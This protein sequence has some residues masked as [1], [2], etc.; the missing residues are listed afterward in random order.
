MEEITKFNQR[1]AKQRKLSTILTCGLLVYGFIAA[2]PMFNDS[3]KHEETLYCNSSNLCE[4]SNIKHGIS[5]LIDRERRNQ[6]FDNNIR[7]IKILPPEDDK[8]FVWG[9]V[10][11][12]FL[13]SSYA[14]SKSITN[15]QEKAIHSQF[16]LLKIKA[17]ENDLLEQAHINLFEFSKQ[18]QAEITKQAIARQTSETIQAM[19]SEAELQLDHLNG[20]L[21]GELSLKSHELQIAELSK[22]IAENLLSEAELKRKL[23]KIN[24]PMSDAKQSTA[25]EQVKQIL[26]EALKNHEDGWLWT[27][28]K[29][30]KPLWIIGEQGTGKTNTS[31]AVG[32]VRKYCLGVAVFR[33]ADRHLNGANSKVWKLLEAKEKADN[34]LAII[35]VLQDTYERRLKRI[36]LDLDDKQAEQF[37]LDEFTHLKDIDEETVKKF[38]KSTFSDTRKAKERFIGVTHLG[39][40]E[41]FGDGTA[42]MR[43]AGSILIEKFTADGEKPLSRVVIKH[44]L[45][46]AQGNKLEDVEHTLPGWFEAFTIHKHFND[47]PIDF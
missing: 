44:G 12:L 30:V 46:D 23:E 16:K 39:T 9:I 13:L 20:Q 14:L 35:E 28:I 40:N 24:K 19:K 5:Y 33:I 4:G 17:L 2:I 8:A 45:A 26:I 37:L 22:Q 31:V 32:L 41:A 3:V 27:I 47:K 34:D 36:G 10:S 11:S 21:Q 29:A 6:L 7:V 18:N 42:A 15:S 38:I 1:L 43:K 25:D